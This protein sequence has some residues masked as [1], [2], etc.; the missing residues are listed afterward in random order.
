MNFFAAFEWDKAILIGS[1]VITMTFILSYAARPTQ[2]RVVLKKNPNSIHTQATST[3]NPSLVLETPAE[4]STRLDDSS[5][6]ADQLAQKIDEMRHL[7]EEARRQ[8][9]ELADA[10][11]QLG[12]AQRK[13]SAASAG[14]EALVAA[15]PVASTSVA[16]TSVAAAPPSLSVGGPD[17]AKVTPL[18]E[19]SSTID[20]PASEKVTAEVELPADS[21]APRQAGIPTRTPTMDFGAKTVEGARPSPRR[22]KRPVTDV[23]ALARSGMSK[24]A[25]AAQLRLPIGEVELILGLRSSQERAA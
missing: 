13:V 15:A 8:R 21:P 10:I 4:L 25:I 19:P 23:H 24:T 3:A 22:V 20:S 18:E 5:G 9:E 12:Q 2:R 6:Y 17:S 14:T 11:G 16:A 7:L 1:V